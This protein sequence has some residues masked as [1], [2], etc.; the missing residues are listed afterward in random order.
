VAAR[1]ES[2]ATSAI[3]SIK[4]SYPHSTGTLHFLKLDLS[5]LSTIKASA[6]HFLDREDR[7]DVLWNNAGVMIPGA[8]STGAQGYEL[9]YVTNVLGPYLFTRL[10]L[11]VLKKTAAERPTGAVRVCWAS[12]L[13]TDTLTPKRGITFAAD[14][15]PIVKGKGGGTSE[16]GVSKVAN[17]FLGYEFSKRFGN[18]DGV[19]HN[20]SD[21][22]T[23][24][25][26]TACYSPGQNRLSLQCRT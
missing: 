5:D 4:S 26:R 18:R 3:N 14:G 20:V 19:M 10:L 17:Y 23:F 7:L 6:Q 15:S 2:K 13:G 1:T 16:Y 12:S 24:V 22:S 11:P 9:Q 25:L 21:V 8:G